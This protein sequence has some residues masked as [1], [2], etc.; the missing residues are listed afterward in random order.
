MEVGLM[1]SQSMQIVFELLDLGRQ[2]LQLL[3]EAGSHLL[4]VKLHDFGDEI[5]AF[6]PRHHSADETLLVGLVVAGH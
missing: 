6:E 1:E 2:N 3:E 4:D 5:P